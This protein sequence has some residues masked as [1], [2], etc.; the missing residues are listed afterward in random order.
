MNVSVVRSYKHSCSV[1]SGAQQRNNNSDAHPGNNPAT[2]ANAL[3]ES[4]A[5]NTGSRDH[6]IC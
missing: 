4:H 6:V 3:L 1:F 2:C 5:C